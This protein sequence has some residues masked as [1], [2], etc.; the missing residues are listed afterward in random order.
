MPG[1]EFT[2]ED[3]KRILRE[4][5]GDAMEADLDA[6][7]LDTEFD[8]LGYDSLALLETGGRIEREYGITLDEAA[9]ADAITPGALVGVVNEH[10]ALAVGPVS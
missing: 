6:D 10:L 7:I 9:L 5:S 1:K 8:D 3:L 2:L 4:G